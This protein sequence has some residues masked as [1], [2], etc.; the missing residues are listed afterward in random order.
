V[1]ILGLFSRPLRYQLKV[2]AYFLKKLRLRR[3]WRIRYQTNCKGQRTMENFNDY[4]VY[5]YHEVAKLQIICTDKF[6]SRLWRKACGF[7]YWKWHCKR[8]HNSEAKWRNLLPVSIHSACFL[9]NVEGC[10]QRIVFS[11]EKSKNRFKKNDNI[12]YFLI[13]KLR[14]QLK[15]RFHCLAIEPGQMWTTV[16]PLLVR[17]LYENIVGIQNAIRIAKMSKLQAILYG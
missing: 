14:K 2:S 17:S 15:T 1:N 5:S 7:F 16:Y 12:S 8:C 13:W 3:R 11:Q 4:I 6:S 9:R 10:H